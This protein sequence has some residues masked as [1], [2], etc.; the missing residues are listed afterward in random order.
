MTWISPRC[1]DCHVRALARWTLA[2]ISGHSVGKVKSDFRKKCIGI[3]T[4][5]QAF[6]LTAK[7]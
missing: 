5:H 3:V 2:V 4:N 1:K 6:I 7:S